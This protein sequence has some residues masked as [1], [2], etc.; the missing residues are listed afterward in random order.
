[1]ATLAEVLFSLTRLSG[2]SS[3]IE[4]YGFA[5]L[6]AILAHQVTHD[7]LSGAIHYRSSQKVKESRFFPLLIARCI[8]AL[9]LGYTW[10]K[11]AIFVEAVKRSGNFLARLCLPDGSFP[12]VLYGYRKVNRWPAWVAP[13]G[14]MV[15]ALMLA[16]SF[17]VEFDPAPSLEWILAGRVDSGAIRS[18]VGY[19]RAMIPPRRKDP[20]DQ[21]ASCGWVDKAFRLFSVLV[22]PVGLEAL[23]FEGE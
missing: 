23:M 15:R 22:D 8:P 12:Q 17:A 11:D 6:D 18:A 16:G 1:L 4:Q 5:C 2:E 21:I 7:N 20:R 13:A 19:G 3:W 14:D 9:I 10:T